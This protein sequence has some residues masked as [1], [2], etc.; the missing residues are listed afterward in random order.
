MVPNTV[1]TINR[2]SAEEFEKVIEVKLTQIEI[3]PDTQ[4]IFRFTALP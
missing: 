4:N 2:D 1:H 3:T